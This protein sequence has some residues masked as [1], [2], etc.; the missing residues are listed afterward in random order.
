MRPNGSKSIAPALVLIL[1][2][3]AAIVT[4]ISWMA[5]LYL[6]YS[7]DYG[8]IQLAMISA[9]AA[10]GL[11]LY[12]DFRTPPW[13][14]VTYGPVAPWLVTHL[15]PLFGRGLMAALAAGRATVIA[16]TLGVAMLVFALAALNRS[17]LASAAIVALAFMLSPMTR[18]EGAEYRVDLIAML[19]NFLGLFIYELGSAFASVPLFVAAFFTKQGQLYGILTV[20]LTLCAMKRFRRAAELGAAWVALTAAVLAVLTVSIPWFWLN[21][22][23]ALTPVLD[24]TAPFAFIAH[25]IPR[26][27]ALLALAA[28]ALRRRPWSLPAW[29]F[30]ATLIEN[31]ASCLR[32][33]SGPYYFLPAVAA[34]AILSAGS[35]DE[36][37][38]WS[39]AMRPPAQAAVGLL[40]ALVLCS[41]ALFEAAHTRLKLD[42]ALV[43]IGS[44]GPAIAPATLRMLRATKGPIVATQAEYLL[45]DERPNVMWLE[46]LVLSQ[47]RHN[48]TFDDR[49][50]LDAIRRREIAAFVMDGKGLERIYRGRQV[51]WPEL[52]DA[53]RDN[54][55]D[56]DDQGFV[57][58]P[59]PRPS[60]GS[61]SHDHSAE[62]AAHASP[63][64]R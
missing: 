13:L 26:H 49:A 47:M 7:P 38:V 27:A 44:P 9:R 55:Q 4:L 51:I 23:G 24:P 64:A 39:T 54:Y 34:A 28:I 63:D 57:L 11:P 40:A 19:F 56:A 43:P 22:F 16:S 25:E 15:A 31:S 53:I 10:A 12:R 33:G 6:P 50:L 36:L 46:L 20:L 29:L 18:F 35:L 17:S 5:R 1:L 58:V 61:Q 37:F 8:P 48:G 2:G 59:K 52:R 60:A 21:T 62:T 14:P 3:A 32:W 41:G 42:F 45:A 30:V